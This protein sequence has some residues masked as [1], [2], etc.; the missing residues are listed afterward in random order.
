MPKIKNKNK[1]VI[2]LTKTEY[3]A[4]WLACGEVFDH[5]DVLQNVCN[6]DKMQIRA[7][8]RAYEKVKNADH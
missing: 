8:K 6:H 5:D 3:T 2:E 7:A 1:V 4:F